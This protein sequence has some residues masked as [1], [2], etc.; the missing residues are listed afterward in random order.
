[1]GGFTHEY[2]RVRDH[3]V[4][5]PILGGPPSWSRRKLELDGEFQESVRPGNE[6]QRTVGARTFGGEGGQLP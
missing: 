2:L 1:M 4:S 6:R 5:V 3:S